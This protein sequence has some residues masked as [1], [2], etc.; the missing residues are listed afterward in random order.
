MSIPR[1]DAPSDRVLAPGLPDKPYRGIESFRFVDQEIFA[2]RAEEI[3]ELLSNSVLYRA[4]LLYGDS[5][6]GKSSLI[7][8]GLL[9]RALAE[10]YV[11]DRL[12]VQPIAG[13]EIKIERI[14]TCDEPPIYLPSNF[15][16]LEPDVRAESLELSIP[17]FR[18]RLEQ[19][20][21]PGDQAPSGD[22]FRAPGATPRPLLI[23][24][25]FEEFITLFEE[26]Q[27]GGVTPEEKSARRQARR[28]QLHILVTLIKLIR[29]ETLPVKII[30][31][32]REDYLAKLSLLFDHCP[33]VLDHAQRLLPPRVDLLPEI[34]RAPF[35][36]PALRTRF[37]RGGGEARS[38]ISE[39]LAE[40]IATELGQ[41]GVADT[42]NLTELQIVCLRLWKS[43]DPEALFTKLG[44]SGLLDAYVAD[45]VRQLPREL[46]DAAVGLLAQMITGSNTRN[47]VAEEDLLNRVTANGEFQPEQLK[48]ALSELGK[49]QIV[50]R[51]LR[52]Q[53]Y[54][55]EITSEYLVPW[56]KERVAERE[57]ANERRLA[58]DAK[59]KAEE[60]RAEAVSKFQAEQHRRRVMSYLLAG[61]VLLLATIA[62]LGYFVNK[63]YKR[64]EV[65]ERELKVAKDQTEQI[66]TVLKLV[67]SPNQE[68]ALLGIAQL[69]ALFYQNKISADLAG[70]IIQPALTSPN[71]NVR[72]AGYDMLLRAQQTRTDLTASLVKAAE[73]NET[74]AGKIPPR[75][76]IHIA[77]DSQTVKAQELAGMLRKRGYL[78]PSIII[79]GEKGVRKNELRYFRDSEPGIPTPKHL[80]EI[81]DTAN[82]GKWIPNRVPGY[83]KSAKVV[84]GQFELWLASPDAETWTGPDSEHQLWEAQ[85]AE[86]IEALEVVSNLRAAV[87]TP[88][89]KAAAT[90]KLQNVFSAL[91]K[92]PDM[93]SSLTAAGVKSTDK[94]LR[95]LLQAL[96]RL[97][98]KVSRDRN[99]NSRVN[100]AI[101]TYGK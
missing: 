84:T 74:L 71:R 33:E 42:V 37:L 40:K 80:L 8:A 67:V 39:E 100:R 4:I 60:D 91:E 89:E 72:Q 79:S 28:A 3:W 96:D 73:Y 38:E 50:R 19:L 99:L 101:L 2:A 30:F 90:L 16:G 46:Q 22:L 97:K 49:S 17:A 58:E 1:T 7:N 69:E 47:I 35:V 18:K 86:H 95:R 25:Q 43:P 23:F 59:K 24:D 93:I 53:V 64:R 66:L 9:P 45:V 51:E 55:Y 52:R 78:V 27:R 76:N 75:F 85:E 26:A 88:A 44:I 48:T 32:F 36:H 41:H 56:I 31:S 83:E 82:M 61:M 20:R 57:S 21:P 54:F 5:G 68:E 29:D 15:T 13:R 87:R 81:L 62:I 34:I 70:A 63:H 65:A 94:E 11:P 14:R 92:D 98:S 6:T 12:R 10:N 77:A